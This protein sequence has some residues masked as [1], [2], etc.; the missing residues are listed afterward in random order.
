MIIV[1]LRRSTAQ[2]NAVRSKL[3][4]VFRSN[5]AS[6]SA[7][8]LPPAV[9]HHCRKVAI[10]RLKP[11]PGFQKRRYRRRVTPK[12]CHLQRRVTARVTRLEVRPGFQKRRYYGGFAPV[13]RQMQRGP[14][15]TVSRLKGLKVR[16]RPPP[17]PRSRPG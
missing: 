4:R 13:R 5:P 10:S 15:V 11:R 17:A 12:Q 8:G 7:T 1:G 16:A 2:C 9:T 3:L 14:L 6:T